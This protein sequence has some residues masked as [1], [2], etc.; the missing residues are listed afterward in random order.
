MYAISVNTMEIAITF[1][2]DEDS[3]TTLL[4]SRNMRREITVCGIMNLSNNSGRSLLT[5]NS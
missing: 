2:C 1:V 5:L 4:K 3:E